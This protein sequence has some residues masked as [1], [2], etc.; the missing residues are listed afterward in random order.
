MA[1]NDDCPLTYF[2]TFT[3]YGT[4]LHGQ[5]PGSVDRQ[6]NQPGTPFLPPD[7]SARQNQH[8]RLE[9]PSYHLDAPRRR[10]VLQAV[11]QVC[12]HR[13]W[14]LL[15][16][17]VRTNHVHVIVG[18]EATP[19][20]VLN[21][22]KAYASRAQNGAGLDARDRKRWT[23]HGSTR[24]LKKRPELEAKIHYVLYEQGEPLE[25][26]DGT[27]ADEPLASRDR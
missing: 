22:F 1:P 3:C 19:E 15:A 10:L 17:H 27:T 2:I 18:A 24:Y 16:A 12:Q 25:V 13:Q 8:N 11:R 9:Q 21:D 26:Y 20:R 23:R 14:T 4:W 7:P 5:D 6:H